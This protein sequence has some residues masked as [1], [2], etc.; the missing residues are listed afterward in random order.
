MTWTVE[1]S[2]TKSGIPV[3]KIKNN[4][5][6]VRTYYG[7]PEDKVKEDLEAFSRGDTPPS[8]CGERKAE[9]SG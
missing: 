7:V 3:A 6:E 9:A 4:D 8:P 2:E 1:W 5:E